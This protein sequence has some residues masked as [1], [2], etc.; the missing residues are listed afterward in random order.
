MNS[1][2]IN[3]IAGLWSLMTQTEIT[4][5][6]AELMLRAAAG[7]KYVYD[8]DKSAP[9]LPAQKAKEPEQEEAVEPVKEKIKNGR[10]QGAKKR[11][12]WGKVGACYRA[13]WSAEKIADEVGASVLT[14]RAGI[15]ARKWEAVKE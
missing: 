9:D 13:G 4:E 6:T 12:D 14:I 10:P 7:I 1:G 8:A 15:S 2:Y 3:D 5:R 11:I